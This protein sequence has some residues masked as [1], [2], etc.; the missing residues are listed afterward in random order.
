[1]RDKLYILFL[2][3]W[4]LWIG[5]FRCYAVE[6]IIVGEVVNETTGEAVPNVN[7]RFRGT[8]IGTTS[9]EN[10]NYVLRVD[11]QA[12]E[13]LIF[14]AVGYYTQRFDIE[15]GA[16]AGLQ[17]ALRE[18][19]ATLSE[20]VVS[21]AENPAIGILRQVRAHRE[22]NDR[23]LH[24]ESSI[25]AQ[26]EQTLYI[27]HISKRHLQRALWKSLQAGMIAQE[28][29]TYILPLYREKQSFR[30]SGTEMIPANDKMS[31]TL[32]LTE[33]SYASLLG[34]E[35]NLNFYAPSVSI[36]GHAFLSPIAAGGNLYY[37]YYIV[38]EDSLSAPMVRIAFRTRNPFYAT[39]NG[40]DHSITV[41]T[42]TKTE[43]SA[44]RVNDANGWTVTVRE[45]AYSVVPDI[46]SNSYSGPWNTSLVVPSGTSRTVSVNVSSTHVRTYLDVALYSTKTVTVKEHPGL[47]QSAAATLAASL[48]N[49]TS[50]AE[51]V[52]VC[53]AQSYVNG[54]WLTGS[55]CYAS[56]HVGTI[57]YASTRKVSDE[58]GYVV[59]ET[60][61]VYDWRQA[62]Q[63]NTSSTK[64][65]WS[66]RT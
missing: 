33:T 46:T 34:G 52:M 36:M 16:M 64:I 23:T 65:N 5:S 22:E 6:T 48:A 35:G 32:I 57:V 53:T 58:E 14:S 51:R 26:R 62:G 56:L 39:V 3:L 63:V 44:R 2:V 24:K 41:T 13:Q 20:V 12:K 60:E 30:L 1:M 38:E 4:A 42:G 18:R 59:T 28:D 43:V 49:N 8:K 40:E 31:Q 66:V 25:V 7:I 47:S 61:E 29:S 27:S 11:M 17:V 10:G 45:V 21:P 15:P 9:D 54:G 55:W 19:T 50:V 37:R